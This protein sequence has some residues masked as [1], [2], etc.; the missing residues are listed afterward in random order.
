MRAAGDGSRADALNIAPR[1]AVW[2]PCS[3]LPDLA[4]SACANCF[5]VTE[6]VCDSAARRGR[7]QP[8]AR[9]DEIELTDAPKC[10]VQNATAAGSLIT[11]ATVNAEAAPTTSR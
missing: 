3:R 7:E 6:L 11:E 4:S 10:A 1:R 5:H 8:R 9:H 2:C